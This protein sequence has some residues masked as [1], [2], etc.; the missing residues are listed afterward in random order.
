ML[1]TLSNT[2]SE[3]RCTLAKKMVNRTYEDRFGISCT[4]KE[5]D[6]NTLKRYDFILTYIEDLSK[7]YPNPNIYEK[8]ETLDLPRVD[9]NTC[10]SSIQFETFP[11]TIENIIVLGN[12]KKE[13]IEGDTFK[14]FSEL[15]NFFEKNFDVYSVDKTSKIINF[16]SPFIVQLN[17]DDNYNLIN[18]SCSEQS[19]NY[20]TY[21]TSVIPYKQ[22]K[23]I[24]NSVPY[25]NEKEQTIIYKD[26]VY[27]ENL[28]VSVYGICEDCIKQI[29]Q[30]VN[31]IK[32][33]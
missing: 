19:N 29:K 10:G 23:K 32:N 1:D 13:T 24:I 7:T 33:Y 4:S 16:H 12:S 18:K 3:I 31:K 8:T 20:Y 22:Y 5:E 9:L 21:Y 30:K 11:I 17:T 14:T 6:I 2:L 27:Y 25:W 15:S 26:E 28:A